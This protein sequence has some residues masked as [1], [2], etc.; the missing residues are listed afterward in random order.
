LDGQGKNWWHPPFYEGLK[1]VLDPSEDSLGFQDEYRLSKEALKIDVV[2]TRK[3]IETQIDHV[4]AQIFKG[5]NLFEYKAYNDSLSKNDYI[6]VFGYAHL[7]SSFRNVPLSDVTITFVVT[8]YPRELVKYLRNERNVTVRDGENGIHYVEGDL[9]PVQILVSK[10][11]D[12]LILKNLRNNLSSVELKE[13]LQAFS[14]LRPGGKNVYTERLIMA[15]WNA[16]R[17]VVKMYPAFKEL[18]LETAE[19]DGWLDDRLNQEAAETAAKT[20]KQIARE[21]KSN[22]VPM[23]VIVTSTKLTLQEVEAL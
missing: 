10:K 3:N 19:E 2:V 13:T 1:A 22:K 12:N 17:E 23:N 18:F 4:V 5:H 8:M 16:F 14:A 6:K 7:Y 21:L 15:N 9:F 20:A 11:H